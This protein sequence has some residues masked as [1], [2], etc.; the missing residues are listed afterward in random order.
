M[1]LDHVFPKAGKK[2]YESLD[3]CLSRYNIK[4]FVIDIRSYFDKLVFKKSIKDICAAFWLCSITNLLT[5][6]LVAYI[7]ISSRICL[8][9]L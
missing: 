2:I 6:N 1:C 3:V 4:S 7:R 5:W 9:L 8:N